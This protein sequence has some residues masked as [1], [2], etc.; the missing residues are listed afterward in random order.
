MSI[1]IPTAPELSLKRFQPLV[2]IALTAT[3]EKV[4]ERAVLNIGLSMTGLQ[5]LSDIV[6]DLLSSAKYEPTMHF[7]N[8]IAQQHPKFPN[9]YWWRGSALDGLGR[10]G[11]AIKDYGRVLGLSPKFAKARFQRG[12]CFE[13][14]GNADDALKEYNRAIQLEPA[15]PDPYYERALMLFDKEEFKQVLQDVETLTILAPNDGLPYLMKAACLINLENYD[16]AS[17]AATDDR[18]QRQQRRDLVFSGIGAVV[19]R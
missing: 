3:D 11:E 1:R 17:V 6:H 15:F 12:R 7:S 18:T 16:G 9:A 13:K 10:T 14:L 2:Q 4:S 19:H 5:A 8:T